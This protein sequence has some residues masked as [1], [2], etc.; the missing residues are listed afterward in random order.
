LKKLAVV[1][2]TPIPRR[3]NITNNVIVDNLII[4]LLRSYRI[5]IIDFFIEAH[6]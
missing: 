4:D 5:G 3:M 2:E 6:L 1:Y